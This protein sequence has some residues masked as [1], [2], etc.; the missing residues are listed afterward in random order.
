MKVLI[1]GNDSSAHVL[2]WK[3]VNSA[4]VQEIILA[5]GNGG[6]SFFASS[7]DLSAEDLAAARERLYDNLRRT[8]FPAG[9]YRDDIGGREL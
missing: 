8:Q 2:G 7:V 3:L 9:V 6:T 1:F 5:P 4:Y